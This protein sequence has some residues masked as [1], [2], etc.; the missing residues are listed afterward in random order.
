[1]SDSGN[2]TIEKCAYCGGTVTTRCGYG[3]ILFFDCPNC[4]ACVSF[5]NIRYPFRVQAD[6][7][8]ACFNRRYGRRRAHEPTIPMRSTR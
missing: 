2:T 5:K 4:G 1:M 7:P 3:G 6:N 8:I